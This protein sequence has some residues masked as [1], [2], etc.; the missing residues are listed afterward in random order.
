M[1]GKRTNQALERNHDKFSS[2]AN[3]HTTWLTDKR[4]TARRML[5]GSL[6][7]GAISNK[8]YE[9]KYPRSKTDPAV[10]EIYI[11]V[12]FFYSDVSEHKL[13]GKHGLNEENLAFFERCVSFLSSDFE[14][15]WPRQ[16]F[17]PWHGFLRLIGFGRL[18]KRWNDEEISIGEKEVWPFLKRADY[19]RP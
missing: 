2:A 13:R 19:Q 7:K 14:F 15:Q 12:W 17:R 16:K 4:A 11:Q 3:Q 10:W 9:R 5:Y 6:R 18:L 8:E 1:S